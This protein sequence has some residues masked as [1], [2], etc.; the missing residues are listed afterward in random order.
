LPQDEVLVDSGA[1]EHFEMVSIRS[2]VGWEAQIGRIHARRGRYCNRAGRFRYDGNFGI[3][4]DGRQR[5]QERGSQGV[6]GLDY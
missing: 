3:G 5:N 2:A 4:Y 6:F 1:R